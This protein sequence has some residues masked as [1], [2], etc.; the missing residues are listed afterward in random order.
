MTSNRYDFTNYKLAAYVI[1]KYC[2]IRSYIFSSIAKIKVM[3][4]INFFGRYSSIAFTIIFSLVLTSGISQLTFEQSFTPA[5]I[6][7]GGTTTLSF[8]ITNNFSTTAAEN[9]AFTNTLPPELMIASLA[10]GSTT[11]PSGQLA[12]PAN[13]S[14]ISFSNGRLGAL[15]SCNIA[16]NVTSSTIGGPYTNTTGD[17]TSNIGNHGTSAADLTVDGNRPGF[18]KSFS[19]STISPGASSRLV[20]TIDNTANNSDLRSIGFVDDFPG[21]LI[22]ASPSNATT[23]CAVAWNPSPGAHSVGA[24]G[25]ALAVVAA[26][27]SCTLEVDVTSPTSS[28]FRNISQELFS[29]ITFN[30][31]DLSSGIAVADL[32]VQNQ[33]L[34]KSFTDDPVAPGASV[35]LQFTLNN[36]DA[37]NSGRPGFGDYEDMTFTDDLEAVLPG[38]D[39]LIFDNMI[40]N[41]CGGNLTGMGTDLISFDGATL[42]PGESCMIRV[43]LGIHGNTPTGSYLNT[44]SPISYTV[45]GVPV[46][47]NTA[48]DNLVLRS[49]PILTKEFLDVTNQ[50]PDP[51]VAG[52]EDV[53]LRFT[54]QNTSP[55]NT[56]SNISFVDDL[57]KILP[58]PIVASAVTPNPPCGAGSSFT[59]VS[60]ATERQ[61]LALTGGELAGGDN[62]S[63]DVT[64]TLPID[65]TQGEYTNTTEE[66]F[67][68]VNNEQVTGKPATDVLL[69]AT[70]P[71]LVKVFSANQIAPGDQVDL[72]FTLE[73]GN[74]APGPA[75]SIEFT[76]DLGS[77]ITGLASDGN[78][79]TGTCNGSLTENLGVLSYSGG[80]LP[81]DGG[82]SFTVTLNVP[83]NAP[84][85]QYINITS[86]VTAI[87][88]AGGGNVNVV[89]V[90]SSDVLEVLSLTLDKEFIN[91][92]VL[93]GNATTLRFTIQNETDQSVTNIAFTDDLDDVISGMT[94]SGLPANNVCGLGS[95]LVA[96]AGSTFLNFSGGNIPANGSCTFDV[97]VNVPPG[98]EEAEYGNLTSVVTADVNG[99]PVTAPSA[100]AGLLVAA[101]NLLTIGKT[102]TPGQAE[103]GS[104]V[105]LDFNISFEGGAT[106]TNISFTDD[107]N[108]ALSGLVATGLPASVCNG[109]TISGS[110]IISM[111]GGSLA[112]GTSC[113]FSVSVTIPANAAVGGYTNT[114]GIVTA[115]NISGNSASA[116]LQVL[117]SSAE[118]R[119]PTA[120]AGPDQLNVE[121]GADVILDGSGSISW[122]SLPLTYTWFANGIEIATGVNPVINLGPG[123]HVVT[124]IVADANGTD[125][126]NVLIVQLVDVEKPVPICKDITVFLDGAGNQSIVASDVDNGSFDICG[127]ITLSVSQTDFDCS[128]VGNP[129]TVFLTVTDEVGLD[130]VCSA[131]VTVVDDVPPTAICKNIT[132]ELN[133]N[134]DTQA[135]ITAGDIDNGSNDAC[136]IAGINASK[137]VFTC[138]DLGDNSVK[139][140]VTDVN[141]NVNTCTSTVTVLDVTPP[142]ITT[143]SSVSLWPPNG[144]YV[145]FDMSD[146]VASI[147]DNCDNGITLSDVVI[148]SGT[149]DEPENGSGDGNTVDD[150]LIAQDCNSVQVRSERKGNGNGRVYTI[151]FEVSDASGNT[152]PA[153]YIITVPKNQN[154]SSAEDDGVAYTETCG[155]SFRPSSTKISNLKYIVTPNPAS[156]LIYLNL[157]SFDQNQAL[158]EIFD[159]SGKRVLSNS[160]NIQSGPSQSINISELANGTYHLVI[161]QNDVQI[162]TTFVKVH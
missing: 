8:K 100:E 55:L 56:A 95:Q 99:Q 4:C 132:I 155:A 115:D 43:S 103:Q 57:T 3:N 13:G 87:V 49:D 154:G 157:S 133:Q 46:S 85:G 88:T 5:T 139:L 63:F 112:P 160:L 72:T 25:N 12:A 44:T 136:G 121:C 73:H 54:I 39:D 53:L 47:G 33:V 29:S 143:K 22:V 11:C 7:P 60:L 50:T 94:A 125:S 98:T 69:V 27:Q 130:S 151:H 146:M 86:D 10:N 48:S 9:L 26:G 129:V 15:K 96:S 67:A 110:S 16:V 58:F 159:I 80:S 65:I 111:T 119:A 36:L 68:T 113:A 1:E 124:L 149:S 101:P 14:T 37:I 78:L 137:T 21:N 42:T 81:V 92:P 89:N 62:C 126:D 77:L 131:I 32:N 127:A 106:A 152:T 142:V 120:D 158:Y 104:V 123:V 156:D 108:A 79:S 24:S 41:T 153:S 28:S 66:I 122:N 45:G 145:N 59:L 138:A 162:N 135:T 97:T 93:P 75:S 31:A 40:S 90:P 34:T 117:Q 116:N 17:L 144:K 118:L 150:I 134:G 2:Y 128:D 147:T 18:S 161:R 30:S 52:G 23:T 35:I 71:S 140:T 84:S 74:N 19:P 105:S 64:L 6:G 91:D 61:G 70:A 20:F 38:T 114:T 51:V 83:A 82:C 109:G 76:D 107:L 148:T 102:F 141:G